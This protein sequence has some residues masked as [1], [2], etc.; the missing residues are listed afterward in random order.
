M[1]VLHWVG[2]DAILNHDRE[3]PCRVLNK[4]RILSKGEKNNNQEN[5]LIKGDN[6][7]VLK[8][9]MPDYSGKVKCIYIDP[10]YNTGSEKWSY[11]DRVNSKEMQEWLR[12]VLGENKNLSRHDKWLCMMYPRLKLLKNLLTEDGAIFVSI[13][14]TE[15]SY[16]KEIL[17]EIFGSKNY[18][19]TIIWHNDIPKNDAKPFSTT[20]EYILC[21]ARDSKKWVKYSRNVQPQTVWFKDEVGDKQEAKE[22]LESLLINP[23]HFF[24]TPKPMRLIKR[25]LEISTKKDDIILDAF[26]G[27]GATGH[28]VM[29]L[30]KE[31][32]GSRKCILVEMEE[33][34]LKNITKER[35]KEAIN[36]EGYD[37]IFQT[38]ELG[39]I[40]LDK[41]GKISNK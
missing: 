22:E 19:S 26:A 16:L 36:K 37:E 21:F 3:V 15:Y 5:L 41:D 38:Y 8:S 30:N 29:Q 33:D 9:L 10:P 18:I 7:E 4:K 28:A 35:L 27:S 25:I 31:D 24:E 32:G 39:E 40:L 13:D 34:I 20:H 6:L 1:P 23:N 2:K 11:N 14:D 12:K 17:N